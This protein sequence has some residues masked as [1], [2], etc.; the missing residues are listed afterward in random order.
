M[1]GFYG[2]EMRF[3][4]TQRQGRRGASGGQGTASEEAGGNVR[5]RLYYKT[6]ILSFIHCRRVPG[7][8]IKTNDSPRSEPL[9]RPKDRVAAIREQIEATLERQ[10]ATPLGR[11]HRCESYVPRSSIAIL[12]VCRIPIKPPSSLIPPNFSNM[13]HLQE[14]L[15]GHRPNGRRS[16]SKHSSHCPFPVRQGGKGISGPSRQY[17]SRVLETTTPFIIDML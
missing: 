17:P 4:D 6:F 2:P 13:L 5:L 11:P 7:L 12:F 8:K 14:F 16:A 10:K 1:F 3:S 15:R 9:I